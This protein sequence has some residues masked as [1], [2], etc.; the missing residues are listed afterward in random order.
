MEENLRFY[1]SWDFNSYSFYFNRYL[2][3]ISKKSSDGYGEVVAATKEDIISNME[4][5]Y[6]NH[7]PI[8][9]VEEG[10]KY[11]LFTYCVFFLL[12]EMQRLCTPY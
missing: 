8:L 9:R 2:L 6:H 3:F 11:R 7:M 10:K 12:K 5:Y 1:F 4:I